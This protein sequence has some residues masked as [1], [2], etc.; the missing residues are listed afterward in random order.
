MW[1][2]LGPLLLIVLLAAGCKTKQ[3][4]V[5]PDKGAP[6]DVV[7]AHASEIKSF[8]LSNLDFHTFSGRAKTRI[9]LGDGA[10][11]V[12]LNLRMERDKSIWVSVTAMLG[13]EV[14]RVLITPDS[15]KILN[16]LQG[17]YISKPFDYVHKYTNKGITFPMLQ[18]LLLANVSPTLLRTDMV[19]V[20]SAEDEFLV[21]GIKDELSYK[22][23]INKANRPFNLSLQRIGANQSMEAYYSNY[24]KTAGYNFPLRITLNMA[25]DDFTLKSQMDFNKVEFNEKVELPF[26]I[27]ARYKEV[28]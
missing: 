4:I 14:A 16:K 15:I 13:V 3:K 12:T 9:E 24:N 28:E 1:S 8:E 26:T 11:D 5:I 25:G 23:R 6:V 22:Y 19:Q 7:S 27:P 18:D 21:V 20:A 2:R 17:E 10:Q